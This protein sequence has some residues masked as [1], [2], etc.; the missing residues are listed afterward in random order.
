MVRKCDD[1]YKVNVNGV[2]TVV[3]H[4]YTRVTSSY[5]Y[6]D[7]STV[8]DATLE[9]IMDQFTEENKLND[10]IV[11]NAT[12]NK[13]EWTNAPTE[14][15]PD[16]RII[17]LRMGDMIVGQDTDGNQYNLAMLNRWGVADFG[18]SAK[19][20][21][22]NSSSR[23]T[24]QLPGES[25]DEAHDMAFVDDVPSLDGIKA[26]VGDMDVSEALS[27]GATAQFLPALEES[28]VEK[29]GDPLRIDGKDYDATS[30]T[31]KIGDP[32]LVMAWFDDSL[33]MRY[34]MFS[35]KYAGIGLINLAYMGFM[36][37]LEKRVSAL[38]KA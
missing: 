22:M 15:L 12:L 8:D 3:R 14:E 26:L 37:G 35:R 33:N 20:F 19:P 11:Y 30:N 18:S 6:I 16:R 10:G 28:Y 9:A 5:H 24:V 17:V 4:S 38:E 1:F 36:S 32:Y 31:Y 27:N 29:L 25:G 2:V 34:E 23:P 21:N 13:V 7:G